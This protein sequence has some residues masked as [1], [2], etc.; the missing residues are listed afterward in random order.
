MER[1]GLVTSEWFSKFWLPAQLHLAPERV[2]GRERGSLSVGADASPKSASRSL[3]FL[4]PP[5]GGV[6][7][8][9]TPHSC[10][11]EVWAQYSG[12]CSQSCK[13]GHIFSMGFSDQMACI[14]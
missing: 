6:V 1:R 8:G 3:G 5:Q 14:I 11:M 12:L 10:A 13:W 7:V 2:A 4:L 9:S